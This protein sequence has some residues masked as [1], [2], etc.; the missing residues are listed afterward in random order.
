MV[1]PVAYFFVLWFPFC[2]LPLQESVEPSVGWIGYTYILFLGAPMILLSLL[3]L[4]LMKKE[5]TPDHV[6]FRRS[7]TALF[8]LGL[9]SSGS[10]WLSECKEMTPPQSLEKR[11][12]PAQPFPLSRK[13]VQQ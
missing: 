9:F 11:S 3:G 10:S 7:I 13:R 6:V 1:F 12:T 5:K 2:S 4:W 8:L